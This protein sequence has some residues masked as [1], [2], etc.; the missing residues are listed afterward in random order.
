[1]YDKKENVFFDINKLPPEPGI[2]V[3]PISMSRISNAQSAK[4]CWDYMKIFSPDK[5]IRPQVGLNFIYG[6]Y[7]YFN[8]EEKAKVLKSKFAPLILSHKNEFLKI[9]GKNPMYIEKAFYFATWNQ[10]LL[11]AKEFMRLYGELK[12]IYDSDKIFQRF[13]KDDLKAAGIEDLSDTQLAFFLE[14]TLLYY[15]ISKGQVDMR[16]DFVQGHEKWVLWCYPGKPLKCQMYLAKKN[17]FG[18]SNK[19]NLYEHAMYDLEG[20]KLYDATKIDLDSINF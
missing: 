3:F 6:D 15:L 16:N 19:K 2:L 12:S 8:S 18:F 11:E 1:M 5:I 13:M 20:Q 14:E 10:M 9:V 17:F 4:K 7:L